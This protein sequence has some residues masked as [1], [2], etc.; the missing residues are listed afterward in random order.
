MLFG[1]ELWRGPL[2]FIIAP[3]VMLLFAMG[4]TWRRL[5]WIWLGFI[6]LVSLALYRGTIQSF[7]HQVFNESVPSHWGK[8][9]YMTVVIVSFAIGPALL[10]FALAGK[11]FKHTQSVKSLW[12]RN[13]AT[14]AGCLPLIIVITALVYN[15]A[16]DFGKQFEPPAGA[17]RLSGLVPP[18]ITNPFGDG[19]TFVL[20]PDG[21]LCSYTGL[22]RIPLTVAQTDSTQPNRYEPNLR[23]TTNSRG[24]FIGGSN[25]V[26]IATTHSELIG[27]KSDGSLW[28]VRWSEW[29][30]PAGD[31]FP[32]LTGAPRPK[33]ATLRQTGP[34]I[35]RIGNESDWKA[36]AGGSLHFIT[37]KRDGTIWGWGN[38]T[39]QQLGEGP[40]TFTNGPVR[41]GN[42]SDW[43]NVFAGRDCSF[44]VKRDGS[45]WKWG[46]R[47]QQSRE[48]TVGSNPVKLDIEVK[49]ARAITSETGYQNYD[50]ILD[51]RGT[52]WGIGNIFPWHLVGRN[53][54]VAGTFKPGTPGRL[55]APSSS[56]IAAAYQ[57]GIAGIKPD[58]TLWDQD[59]TDDRNAPIPLYREFGKR[60]DW[61][62]VAIE[63]DSV[64]A[65]AKD[66]TICR[67]GE[68][69][70]PRPWSELLAPIRRVTWSINLLDAA[71]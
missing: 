39:H 64:L 70:K 54:Y 50:L 52:L 19:P 44:G 55:P 38:N 68:P 14:W 65:L 9:T 58:G 66:G 11:N 17:A 15:R 42:E 56:A 36:V 46:A 53:A 29:A 1:H 48:N 35:E 33:G 24:Q 3:L 59:A 28:S 22:E 40:K 69:F 6:A 71:K 8:T 67:F 30:G 43:T 62:A 41:I 37:L 4:H 49:G 13:V 31:P 10:M 18:V 16:W 20:L 25:W 63:W 47:A 7:L 51:E 57:R 61:I 21:R 60:T 32:N 23:A 26:A 12:L 34:K 5:G 2:A 45:I 27:I